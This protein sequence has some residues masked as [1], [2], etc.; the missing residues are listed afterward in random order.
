VVSFT[1]RPHYP[2]RNSLRCPLDSRLGEPQN[3]SGR[4][5][6]KI[7]DSTGTRAP[8]PRSSSP[9]PVAIPTALSRLIMHIYIWVGTRTG[10]G[11][12]KKT[13]I[14]RPYRESNPVRR[15]RGRGN[16][17]FSTASRPVLGAQPNQPPIQLVPETLPQGVK[18]PEHI[19]KDSRLIYI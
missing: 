1:P 3:R 8:T 14:F 9:Q 2:W 12:V 11:A 5:E 16:F 15:R 4:G 6:E 19:A 17:L 10:L 7:I 13:K 18:Q